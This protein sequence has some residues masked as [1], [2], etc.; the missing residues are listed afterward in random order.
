MDRAHRLGQK[1]VVSVYRLLIRDSLEERIL[2][3]QRFKLDVANA[4]V[5]ADQAGQSTLDGDRLL[6]VLARPQ[7]RQWCRWPDA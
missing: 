3:L 4:V 6:D 5:G 7:V 1:R 2:G